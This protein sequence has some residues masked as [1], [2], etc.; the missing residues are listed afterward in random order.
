VDSTEPARVGFLEVSALDVSP[1]C[2]HTVS[3]VEAEAD[4]IASQLGLGDPDVV[5]VNLGSW[6]LVRERCAPAGADLQGCVLGGPVVET[7]LTALPHELVH[8]LRSQQAGAK[9]TAFF[10]EGLATVLGSGPLQSFSVTLDE[11]PRDPEP[12][13]AAID[14]PREEV[15]YPVAG[16]VVAWWV[17]EFGLPTVID[18]YARPS[19]GDVEARFLAV[20]GETIDASIRRWAR[21]APAS[22][23]LSP[24]CAHSIQLQWT[25]DVAVLDLDLSCD[26]DGGGPWIVGEEERSSRGFC[27]Q[28]D[29]SGP[30][31]VDFETTSSTARVDM[32]LIEC[33]SS[34]TAEQFADKSIQPTDGA[35]VHEFAGCLWKGTV[36]DALENA[37]A[38]HV[39]F[40]R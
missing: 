38:V 39:E 5:P 29:A 3:V 20:F 32:S 11:G 15:S 26:A 16:H 27:L 40:R 12:V 21:E 9:T 36:R 23:V 1:L 18:F 37:G 14:V 34:A 17:E 2:G 24:P 13:L 33:T 25:G 4:R 30:L 7:T 10:E 8:A 22:V 6:E 19:E 35:T 28:V 31:E